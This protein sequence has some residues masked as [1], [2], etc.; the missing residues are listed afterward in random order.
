MKCL[1]GCE[2]DVKEG[3]KYING[4]NNWNKGKKGLQKAWNKGKKWEEMSGENNPMFGKEHS[5]E[6]KQKISAV[7]KGRRSSRKGCNLSKETKMKISKANKG[8]K[9]WNKGKEYIQ[10]KGQ[11]NHNWSGGCYSYWHDLAW[12][13]FGKDCCQR[14][15]ITNDEHIKIFGK[16]LHMHCENHEYSKLEVDNWECLCNKC[17]GGTDG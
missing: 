5:E 9:A 1:C 8:K 13:M 6:T 15:K 14:C 4:H 11:K 7:L 3:N 12:K 16:R 2:K 17:H 10:I